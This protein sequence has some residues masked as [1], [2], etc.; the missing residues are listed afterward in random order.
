MRKSGSLNKD[1]TKISDSANYRSKQKLLIKNESKG[2]NMLKY[3]S[4]SLTSSS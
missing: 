4:S 1:V 2:A 3:Q